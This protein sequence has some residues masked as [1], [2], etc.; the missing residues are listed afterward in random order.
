MNKKYAAIS[1]AIVALVL[2]ATGMSDVIAQTAATR[3][4]LGANKVAVVD[5]F[6]LK[7]DSERRSA[8]FPAP[9]GFTGHMYVHCGGDQQA[10]FAVAADGNGQFAGGGGFFVSVHQSPRMGNPRLAAVTTNPSGGTWQI[11]GLPG[12]Q[13]RV[14]VAL[15]GGTL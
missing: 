14:T 6:V 12:G 10:I 13:T 2:F 15:V 11:V 5:S 3:A 1:V 7:I 9:K 8:P 4:I